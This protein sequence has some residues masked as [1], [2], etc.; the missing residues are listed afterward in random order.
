[1]KRN[2]ILEELRKTISEETKRSVEIEML[3]QDVEYLKQR[4]EAAKL[5]C[6]KL[7]DGTFWVVFR[8]NDNVFLQFYLT[9]EMAEELCDKIDS[10]YRDITMD[11]GRKYRKLKKEV[12][13]LKEMARYFL[14]AT[15]ILENAFESVN[16]SNPAKKRS[17]PTIEELTQQE[18]Q[19]IINKKRKP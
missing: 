6:E 8:E 10:S 18:L 5:T 7:D 16:P 4:C 15:E 2:P 3:K 13:G 11:S 14:K 1:M 9:K 19:G 17:A 12:L